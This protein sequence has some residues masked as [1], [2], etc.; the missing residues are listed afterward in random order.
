VIQDK[1]PENPLILILTK[2]HLTF[3]FL[4]ENTSSHSHIST[5]KINYM[6]KILVFLVLFP[7]MLQAQNRRTPPTV[8][9]ARQTETVAFEQGN[10]VISVGYGIG[11]FSSAVFNFVTDVAGIENFKSRTSG[12]FFFKGEYAVAEA[13]GVGL[14]VANISNISSDFTF[15]VNNP[16]TGQEETYTA[17]LRRNNT[18]V[19]VRG[20]YHFVRTENWDV[21]AGLGLGGRFG[22]FK[23]TT[24]ALDQFNQKIP[25]IPFINP[26]GFEVTVGV[27]YFPIPNLGIY[28]EF[29]GAK[30]LL[31]FGLCGK[32]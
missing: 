32:F 3:H 24:N 1:N 16:T 18:S 30:G 10:L 29:G 28:S 20:N 15:K 9:N 7:V 11:N 31:Q 23:V 26:F 2:A 14:V 22:G 12:P 5:S 21:Y 8:R 27:R 6:K 17:S 13:I 4:Q 19:M 25:D